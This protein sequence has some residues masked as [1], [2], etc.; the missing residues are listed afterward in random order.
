[1]L[2]IGLVFVVAS[3][4]LCGAGLVVRAQQAPKPQGA[5]KPTVAV[6]KTATCGC[7][8]KWVDH[9][10]AAG[11]DVRATDVDNIGQVKSSYGVPSDLGS[12]H[13]SLV[14]GYVVE[15]HVPADVVS[16]LLR[17][18]PKFAGLAVPGMPVGSPGMEQPGRVMSY[19]IIG[20]ERSGTV[21]VYDKR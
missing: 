7:C 13:T 5:A 16:R 21:S 8:S 11:F 6:Y 3:I 4:A 9:M 17:E 1:M 20:F 12:C 10:R 2:R 14:G 15:G 18:K 19:E